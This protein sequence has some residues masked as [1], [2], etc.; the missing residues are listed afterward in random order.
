MLYCGISDIGRRRSVN[1]DN[2][3][4]RQFGENVLLLTVCDGMGGQAG[5]G[6]ASSLALSTFVDEVSR[7]IDEVLSAKLPS[8]LKTRA[9]K[10][11]TEAAVSANDAVFTR[12]G[13]H[14]SLHGMG[15][16]LVSSLI[17]GR[18]IF[19]LNIGDSRMYLISENE[20]RQITKDHSYVQYLVDIGKITADEA[21]HSINRNIIT[22]AVGTES[23]VVSD[24]IVT[25][26]SIDDSFILLCTDG[27]TNHVDNNR[28]LQTLQDD[29]LSIAEMAHSLVEHANDGGGSDNIT[30]ILARL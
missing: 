28:I 2:F 10:L 30:L 11:M 16:T 13:E 14:T 15:T 26:R 25:E 22:R 5:G 29:R 21:K 23:S 17:V 20:I 1:Q 18:T 12:A 7:G 19:T 3:Y 27:L 9:R 24:I 6:E 4:L 8:S